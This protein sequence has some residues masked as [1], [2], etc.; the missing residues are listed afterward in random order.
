[1]S[2]APAGP[3]EWCGGQQSWTIVRGEMWTRCK[4]GCLPLFDAS[5]NCP[6]NSEGLVW[7]GDLVNAEVE[8]IGVRGSTPCEGGDA[9]TSDI[10]SLPF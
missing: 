6:S 9:K 5:V 1:M 3:C 4:S 7:V 8:R 2:P 10:D